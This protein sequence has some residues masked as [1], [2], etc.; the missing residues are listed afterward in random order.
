VDTLYH[1]MKTVYEPLLV[2]EPQL[3]NTLNSQLKNLVGSLKAGLATT[4]RQ[5]D[6]RHYDEKDLKGILSPTDEIEFWSDI[7]KMNVAKS[8]DDRLRE[9]AEGLGK[10]FSEIAKPFYEIDNLELIQVKDLIEKVYDT[11][12]NIWTNADILPHYGEERM[13]H[14][15]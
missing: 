13:R 10:L 2:N 6:E 5:G 3:A 11:C 7:E 15:M 9:K 8:S 12:D 14:F 4:I 1:Y